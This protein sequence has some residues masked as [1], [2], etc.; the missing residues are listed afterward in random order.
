LSSPASFDFSGALLFLLPA[1]LLAALTWRANSWPPDIKLTAFILALVLFFVAGFI[2]IFGKSA[3]R[4]EWF[5][6]AFQLFA[7][8][9]PNF[10]LDRVVYFLQA[11]SA[12]IAEFFFDLSGVPVLR[13][14]FFFR[15]PKF[16]IEVAQECSGIRSSIALLILALLVAHFTFRPFWKKALFVFAGLLMMLVKNGIRIAVLAILANYVN[17]DFLLGSLHHRGGIIFF[18]VGLALLFPV[19]WLLKRGEPAP[20][21]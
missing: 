11:G 5:P 13:E 6:L 3:A 17:P 1:A 7:V 21:A 20:A 4:L 8:P 2:G 19:Y 18:I 12:D 10:L 14:G 16:T 15:L 9:F